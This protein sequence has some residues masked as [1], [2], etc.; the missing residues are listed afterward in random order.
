VATAKQL[1]AARTAE[2]RA[3]PVPTDV[4]VAR[5]LSADAKAA[6]RAVDASA[7]TR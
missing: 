1:A 7:A 4:V 3:I 6:T 5:A 2:G